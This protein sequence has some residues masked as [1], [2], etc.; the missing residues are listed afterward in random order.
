MGGGWWVLGAGWGRVSARE[1]GAD[2]TDCFPRGRQSNTQYTH[3]HTR[4]T[5]VRTH[6]HTQVHTFLS[7]TPLRK[8]T[9]RPDTLYVILPLTTNIYTHTHRLRTHLTRS[10]HT[11]THPVTPPHTNTLANVQRPN[12]PL[13][14]SVSRTHARTHPYLQ[15]CITQLYYIYIY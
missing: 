8:L 9:G 4:N 12:N 13:E 6:T 5:Q 2:F 10:T 11:H 7:N 14:P 3:T 15:L 1:G